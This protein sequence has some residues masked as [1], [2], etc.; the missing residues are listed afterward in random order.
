M[1]DNRT[2]IYYAGCLLISL[3]ICIIMSIT[4]VRYQKSKACFNNR[5]P[6]AGFI[7]IINGPQQKQLIEQSQKFASRHQFEVNIS[8]Y[9]PQGDDFQIDLVREDVEIVIGNAVDLDKFY[10]DFYNYDCINPIDISEVEKL[11]DGLKTYLNEI[12]GVVIIEEK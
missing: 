12:P 6:L 11:L 3:L 4:L 5:P 8:Y 9:T 1:H 10:V 2:K 7:L